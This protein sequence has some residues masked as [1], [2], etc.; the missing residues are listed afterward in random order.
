[1]RLLLRAN[2]HR[3]TPDG[4]VEIASS[5]DTPRREAW[6]WQVRISDAGS[7]SAAAAGTA[8]AVAELHRPGGPV[9]LAVTAD[10][11]AATPHA[12]VIDVSTRT[13]VTRTEGEI[14]V[15]VAVSGSVLAEGRHLLGELDALVLAGEDPLRLELEP[16]SHQA[17]S[18][19]LAR[20]EPGG[21]DGLTWVP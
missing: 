17:A 13:E 19:A 8:T 10:P 7:A 5:P 18:M 12:D 11:H 6:Q 21:A 20:L 16:G 15:L 3:T 14:V 2:S 4:S 9:V 1:M